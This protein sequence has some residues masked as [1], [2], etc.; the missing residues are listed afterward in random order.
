MPAGRGFEGPRLAARRRRSTS[1]SDSS[2]A[3]AS[4]EVSTA[5]AAIFSPKSWVMP[6]KMMSPKPPALI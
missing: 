3:I 6:W 5:P 4:S 1:F 2:A